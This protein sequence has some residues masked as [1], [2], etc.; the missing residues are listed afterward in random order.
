MTIKNTILALALLF[1]TISE[2]VEFEII[3]DQ[4][5][6]HIITD[7]SGLLSKLAHLHIVS[8][9]DLTGNIIYSPEQASGTAILGMNV[10]DFIVDKPSERNQYP[11]YF[12]DQRSESDIQGTR[13]NMLGN[14]LLH[15]EKHPVVEVAVKL[16]AYNKE[17]SL[18][19][20]EL[21]INLKGKQ[22]TVNRNAN[23][24]V[25]DNELSVNSEFELSNT[26]L[27]L[28]PFT[29]AAGAMVVGKRLKFYVNLKATRVNSVVPPI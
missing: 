4:S 21:K 16:L 14:K 28:K 6:I 22:F 11:D 10:T 2:A 27:G 9:S 17:T 26:E 15:A 1:S 25:N 5:S 13:K 18:A 19:D 20:L 23:L 8:V 24:E 3:P 12:K 29:A 7:R